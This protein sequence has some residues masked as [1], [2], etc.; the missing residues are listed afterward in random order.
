MKELELLIEDLRKCF[1]E[2]Q[3]EINM[4][5]ETVSAHVISELQNRNID[6]NNFEIMSKE[7]TKDPFQK[8]NIIT[9]FTEKAIN[10]KIGINKIG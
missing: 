4:S 1:R 2:K 6:I 10:L 5:N 8:E 9:N 7:I 3:A